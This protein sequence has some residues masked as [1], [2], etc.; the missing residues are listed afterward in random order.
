LTYLRARVE[1]ANERPHLIQGE[2]LTRI[3]KNNLLNLLGV[4]LPNTIGGHSAGLS[5]TLEARPD[6]TDLRSRWPAR[7]KR[8]NCR[9][10]KAR[11]CGRGLDQRPR[12]GT[13]RRVYFR[14]LPMESRST[15]T[16]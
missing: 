15:K 12:G 13:N 11:R 16:I 8:P 14:R 6:E 4:N 1:L 2:T 10:A 5:D 7:W 3:G 9:V